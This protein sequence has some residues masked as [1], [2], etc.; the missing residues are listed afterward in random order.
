MFNA[1]VLSIVFLCLTGVAFICIVGTVLPL[2]LTRTNIEDLMP[3]AMKGVKAS[4][5]MAGISGVLELLTPGD[6]VVRN[7]IIVIVTVVS[8]AWSWALLYL[9]RYRE[10]RLLS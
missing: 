3:I 5:I 10:R 4:I 7:P 6:A 8:F 1:I 9:L 2:L